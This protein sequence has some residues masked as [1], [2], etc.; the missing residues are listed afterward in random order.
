MRFFQP[1]YYIKRVKD[2]Y[3]KKEEILDRISRYDKPHISTDFKDYHSYI[4]NTDWKDNHSWFNYCFSEKDRVSYFE[5]I[6][7]K[8]KKDIEID[9]SWFNQY[10]KWSGSDHPFHKHDCGHLANIYYVELENKSL[11]TILKHPKTGKEIVP[12]VNEGDLLIFPG[13]ILHKSPRNYTDTRK[14]AIA[15]NS[16]FI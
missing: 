7:K 15:F 9:K 2:H 16:L 11:R 4:S 13:D 1:L 3:L 14:T 6:F 8:F 5:F 12:R 10:Y